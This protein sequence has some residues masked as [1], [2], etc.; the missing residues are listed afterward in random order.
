MNAMTAAHK[1]LPLGV[2]VKVLNKE[3]GQETVVRVNDR[4]PFVKD[5]I[6]DL[7]YS[8]AKKLGELAQQ[9]V[10]ARWRLYEHMAAMAV[11]GGK[12]A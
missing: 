3:N 8:A 9:D 2:F 12:K 4:G 10:A 1:T 11:N 5:R 7:S 6:I